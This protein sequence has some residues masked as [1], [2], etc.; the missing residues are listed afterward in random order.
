MSQMIYGFSVGVGIVGTVGYFLGEGGGALFGATL[1][2]L[3]GAYYGRPG[4][5]EDSAF[6]VDTATKMG[7]ISIIYGGFSSHLKRSCPLT[8]DIFCSSVWILDWTI[9]L[10]V[11]AILAYTCYRIAQNWLAHNRII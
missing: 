1:G 9:L 4:T 10:T 11:D 8:Q 2:G 7:I 5:A 3:A 6:V